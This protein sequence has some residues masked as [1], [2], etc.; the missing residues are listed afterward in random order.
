MLFTSIIIIMLLLDRPEGKQ[1]SQMIWGQSGEARQKTLVL[2]DC[3]T[4]SSYP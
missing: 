4:W 2:T 1:G 3:F